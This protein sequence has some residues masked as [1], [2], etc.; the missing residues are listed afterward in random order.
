MKK[1]K[2]ARQVKVSVRTKEAKKIEE[3][4]KESKWT[5]AQRQAVELSG[6]LAM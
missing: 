3:E 2:Q 4:E 5:R 1:Q 6:T